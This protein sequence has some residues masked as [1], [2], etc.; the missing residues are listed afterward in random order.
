[1][2]KYRYLVINDENKQLNGTI[3]APDE[4]G[5][6]QELNELGFSIISINQIQED[7]AIHNSTELPIFEFAAIDKNQ[8]HVI[9]TIQ[10]EDRYRAYKRLIGEYSFEVE[11]VIDNSLNDQEKEI[12]RKKGAY[13]LQQ[14]LDQE[15]ALVKKKE[16][17]EEKDLKE[18]EKKQLILK[19]QIEFVLDKVKQLLD[20]YEQEIKPD[21]KEKIRQFVDKILRI[22][23]STNLDYIRKTTEELLTFLQKEEIFLNGE[24][25]RQ[26]RTKLLVDAKSM[27]MQL[28]Q[29]GSSTNINI[30]DKLRTWRE[31]HI[32]NNAAPNTFEKFI[33]IV[34]SPIIGPRNED[35]EIIAVKKQMADNNGQLKQYLRLYFQA[36]SPEFKLETANSLKRLWL[37]RKKLKNQLKL[38]RKNI[39]QKD[40]NHTSYLGKISY[41]LLGFSGWLLAFYLIYYFTAIYLTTK[42]FSGILG[43]IQVSQV[44]YFH[45]TTFLKY[46]LA[47]LFLLHSGLSIK[48][49]FFRKNE[50]ASLIITPA[51]L[52]LTILIYLNF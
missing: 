7:E 23:T 3:A 42:N 35:P 21:T 28:R 25:R 31:E 45:K 33:D 8:K 39:K 1:M 36:P 19:S 24:E 4:S 41:E 37:N 44:F 48:M 12:A 38:L 27:M 43:N 9:G 5:A 47:T 20:Q 26:E 15:N 51:F 49:N 29:S 13:D 16:S 34:I 22:R 30:S 52:I 11:Y 40:P 50:V 6:R 17:G 2:P 32:M 10:A 46:F 18:F 14:N